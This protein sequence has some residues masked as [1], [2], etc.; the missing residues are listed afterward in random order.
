MRESQSPKYQLRLDGTQDSAQPDDWDHFVAHSQWG[1]ILQ[2]YRWGQFKEQFGWQAHRLT[3][4][5][6]D[7]IVAGVQVLLRRLPMGRT[8]AYVPR[9]PV[10]APDDDAALRQILGHAMALARRHRA[11]FLKVEPAWGVSDD[12][13]SLWNELGMKPGETVQP[14][15]TIMV[16]LTGSEDTWLGRMKS[17][18][19]Y[20]IRLAGR[21]G[22]T[23]REGNKD[24]LPVFH[25]LMAV[26][27][28]RDHFAVRDLAYYREVWDL[29]ASAGLATL[30]LAEFEGDVLAG[31]MPFVFGKTAWYMYGASSNRH[32]NKMPTY[33]LQ[34]AAMRWAKSRGCATYDLWGVPDEAPAD[35][36]EDI[37]LTNP[38]K[39]SLWGVYRFKKGFGGRHF[40][41][42]GSYDAVLAPS[43]FWAYR[44][45]QKWRHRR[46]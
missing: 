23:V 9:G 30:L 17:K 43:L 27:G 34:L 15:S 44:Q 12:P 2:S 33:A 37:D 29:F 28:Q 19:R 24:D 1:H 11:I 40:R 18:T 42:A 26:T 3:L 45:V 14:R 5:E 46:T 38:P 21:K 32:R 31:L 35:Q 41:S 4:V 16:D 6:Q 13:Q 36:N 20:N 22:I 7:A 39:G 10:V 25:E 8:L